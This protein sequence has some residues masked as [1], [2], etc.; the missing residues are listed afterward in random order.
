[1]TRD[2]GRLHPAAAAALAGGRVPFG[3]ALLWIVLAFLL[4]DMFE[5]LLHKIMRTHRAPIPVQQPAIRVALEVGFLTFTQLAARS[6][7]GPPRRL[8][9][10]AVFR[11]AFPLTRR[12]QLRSSSLR[13]ALVY[14]LANQR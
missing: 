13:S 6:I 9:G 10:H 11:R 1:M 2:S 3:A 4:F 14:L 5:I 8:I 7:Q 12:L